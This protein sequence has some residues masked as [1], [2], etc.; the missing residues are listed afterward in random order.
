M[1]WNG[2]IISEIIHGETD[3]LIISF[4]VLHFF[5]VLDYGFFL[6]QLFSVID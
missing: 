3:F 1:E 6:L 5:F 4:L 2:E